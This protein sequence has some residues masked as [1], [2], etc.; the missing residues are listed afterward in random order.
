LLTGLLFI[1]VHPEIQNWPS[2]LLLSTAL[3]FAYE[4]TGRIT[5]PILIHSIFNATYITAYLL[6]VPQ[7]L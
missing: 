6:G 7:T 2:L 1:I 4:K 5:L 3:G